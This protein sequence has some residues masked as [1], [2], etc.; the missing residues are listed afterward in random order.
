MSIWQKLINTIL[1]KGQ[2]QVCPPA[3]SELPAFCDFI[4]VKNTTDDQLRCKMHAQHGTIY[5]KQ[6]N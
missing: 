2:T 5:R 3:L 1:Y 4:Q 6:G